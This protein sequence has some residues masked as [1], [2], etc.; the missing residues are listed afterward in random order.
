MTQDFVI[1]TQLTINHK[2]DPKKLVLCGMLFVFL[3][4]I[5]SLVQSQDFY[6]SDMVHCYAGATHSMAMDE[7][8]NES[9]YSYRGSVRQ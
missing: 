5:P 9:A 6:S 1:L 4:F 3:Q 7:S 8:G 2:T